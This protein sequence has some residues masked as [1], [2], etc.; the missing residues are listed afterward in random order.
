[1]L[2]DKHIVNILRSYDEVRQ[3]VRIDPDFVHVSTMV[4]WC[5]REHAL[6]LRYRDQSP[7]Y[8]TP[9]SSDTITWEI[10][11]ALERKIVKAFIASYGPQ[12]VFANWTCPCKYS[13]YTGLYFPGMLADCCNRPYE[14]AEYVVK[15][16]KY[17]I[18]GSLDFSLLYE[19]ELIPF[20][21][22][23][24]T[25]SEAAKTAKKAFSMLK[26][27][28]GDHCVQLSLYRKLMSEA[29]LRFPIANYGKVVYVRKEHKFFDTPYKVFT[30][31]FK[32]GSIWDIQAE[33]LKL[34][35]LPVFDTSKLPQRLCINPNSTRA[36]AC[37]HVG[38]C[39]S[40]K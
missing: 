9:T 23:S 12:N 24:I 38:V 1:M 30:L 36:K 5:Q 14:Y 34:S 3:R 10:G 20:E 15:S 33:N 17:R 6:S 16:S 4:S 28:L 31:D 2:E 29:G 32:P 7:V 13:F 21:I 19:G 35:A 39:F 25:D 26:A 27:P 11:R 18:S 40:L 8:K 37:P 22:K